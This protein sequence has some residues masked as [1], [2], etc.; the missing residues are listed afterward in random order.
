MTD[1]LTQTQTKI[2]TWVVYALLLILTGVVAWLAVSFADLS[3]QYV[4]LE[5]YKSDRTTMQDTLTEI[6]TDTRDTRMLL[7]KIYINKG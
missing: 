3:S 2:L 5:R 6:R 4:R 1:G 7:E